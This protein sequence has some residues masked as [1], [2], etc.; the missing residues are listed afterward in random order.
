[1]ALDYLSIPRKSLS[2][3]N[4]LCLTVPQ[5]RRSLLNISFSQGRILISHI[6]NCLSAQT[7]RALMCLGAWSRDGMIHARDLVAVTITPAVVE[8]GEDGDVLM[9]ANFDKITTPS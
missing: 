1:M 5:L 3:Y 8:E 2:A 6:R 7:A 4:S 9:P